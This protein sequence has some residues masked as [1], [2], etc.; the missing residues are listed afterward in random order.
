[1]D[2]SQH[3]LVAHI[4]ALHHNSALL[5][6]YKTGY[7]QQQGWFLPNDGLRHLEHPDQAAKRILKEQ[8]GIADPS[9]KMMEIES[10]AGK[11]ESWHL[12]FDYLAFPRS[13]NVTPSSTIKEAKWFEIDKL[14]AAQDF[15]HHGWG[16]SVLVKHA[17]PIAQSAT[18]R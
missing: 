9:M 12:I 13:M 8:L 10:F 11:D 5:V 15:A 7:D 14:P 1:L 6:K 16:R 17:L 18:T 3:T 2:C 4:A